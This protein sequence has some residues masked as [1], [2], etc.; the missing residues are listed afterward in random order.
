MR[1]EGEDIPSPPLFAFFEIKLL[2][3]VSMLFFG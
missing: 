3:I 1:A 2:C